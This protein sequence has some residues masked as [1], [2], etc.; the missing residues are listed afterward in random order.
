MSAF[1]QDAVYDFDIPEL[2]I[3]QE[4]LTELPSIKETTQEVLRRVSGTIDDKQMK[5]L[6]DVASHGTRIYRIVDC[7]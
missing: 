6:F 4:L 1:D 2:K 5:L 7:D 3:I